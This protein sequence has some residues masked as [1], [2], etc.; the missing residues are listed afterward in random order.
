MTTVRKPKE[1]QATPTHRA[2]SG[3]FKAPPST[4]PTPAPQSPPARK[5]AA[6]AAAKQ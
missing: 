4:E 6:K 1:N 3:K 2:A 5:P